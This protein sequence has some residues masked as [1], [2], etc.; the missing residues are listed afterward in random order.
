MSNLNFTVN[1]YTD[2]LFYGPQDSVPV[3]ILEDSFNIK[4]SF[5]NS[6]FIPPKYKDLVDHASAYIY[7]LPDGVL[8][9]KEILS[10][11]NSQHFK[12]MHKFIKSQTYN[13]DILLSKFTYLTNPSIT[14]V[15]F[16]KDINID[17]KPK[18]VNYR[19]LD[20]CNFPY[21]QGVSPGSFLL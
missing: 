21:K 16:N 3:A 14:N 18:G 2:K 10:N 15:F 4:T 13:K 7:Q 6:Y 12:Y 19:H 11:T 20:I 8:T 9:A 17:K 5:Y 1:K